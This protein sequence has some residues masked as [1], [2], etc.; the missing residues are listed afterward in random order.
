MFVF[1]RSLLY[2]IA[3]TFPNVFAASSINKFKKLNTHYLA[4]RSSHRMKDPQNEIL[5]V[6]IDNRKESRTEQKGKCEHI[7]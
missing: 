6:N 3:P 5:T 7:R 4:A 2:V 1:C